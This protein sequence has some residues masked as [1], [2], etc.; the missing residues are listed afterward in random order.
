MLFD[1]HTRSFTALGGIPARDLQQH[2]DRGGKVKKVKAAR[3]TPAS[4]RCVPATCSMPTSAT[5]PVVG[6]RGWSGRRAGQPAPHLAGRRAAA[7]WLLRQT[8]AW[9]GDRCRT[10]WGEIAHPEHPPF[11][12]GYARTRAAAPDADARALRWLCRAS[13]TGIE[14]LPGERAAQPFFGPLQ[15]VR[16]MVSARLYPTR[17]AVVA[18]DAM[19][20]SH[21][22]LS[23]RGRTRYDWQHYIP[24]VQ[25]KRGAQERRAV[26]RRATGI[27]AAPARDS[28]SRGGDR[29][30]AQVLA[31]VPMAGLESILVAVE[32]VLETGAVSEHVLN[33]LG[34]LSAGPPLE[35]AQTA[36][37]SPRHR[38]PTPAAMTACA[39]RI[40]ARRCPCVNRY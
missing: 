16:Q 6:R 13:G 40:T 32:L 38:V 1:A 21:E 30:V 36:L 24:L 12:V 35:Q 4:P 27:C 8:D 10:L 39:R 33:V 22:R 11:G 23:D 9:L 17:V 26:C 19:V 5:S 7:L 37:S 18:G 2:E 25:K 31:A 29:V 34:R 15:L 3:S 14:H 28:K 20:T